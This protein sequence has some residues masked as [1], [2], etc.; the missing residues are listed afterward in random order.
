MHVLRWPPNAPHMPPRAPSW[1]SWRGKG[2]GTRTG[3]RAAGM[4]SAIVVPHV[5]RGT[6]PPP[7][8][9]RQRSAQSWWPGCDPS[10]LCVC[11]CAGR[12]RW[13]GPPDNPLSRPPALWHVHPRRRRLYHSAQGQVTCR[14]ADYWPWGRRLGSRWRRRRRQRR[15]GG[16]SGGVARGPLTRRGACAPPGAD[17]R[18]A[19][20]R[21][22]GQAQ[23]S[24]QPPLRWARVATALTVEQQKHNEGQGRS[25]TPRELGRGYAAVC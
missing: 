12:M 21:A 25:C 9:A 6:S 13:C 23:R 7:W 4:A 19:H 8:P 18:G 17:C 24:V 20:R 11:A 22:H 3:R 15:G 16:C 10:P 2:A 14:R 5:Q 1:Q